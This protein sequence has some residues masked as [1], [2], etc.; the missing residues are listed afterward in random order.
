MVLDHSL[1]NNKK[2]LRTYQMRVKSGKH[3]QYTRQHDLT[4][5]CEPTVGYIQTE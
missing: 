4:M 3:K 2:K 5:A 1:E